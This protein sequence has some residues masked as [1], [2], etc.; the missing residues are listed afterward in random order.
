M[1]FRARLAF[2]S[3]AVLL[4]ALTF[5]FLLR[6]FAAET[7]RTHTIVIEGMKFMPAVVRASPGER[8]LFHNKDLVPHTATATGTKAFDSG[9]I[10]AG[11]SYAVQL[12]GETQTIDYVCLYHPTMK[13]RIVLERR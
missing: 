4:T 3:S 10:K 12:T 5:A 8:V 7:I 9:L 2:L 11:E 13:G 1:E 6:S